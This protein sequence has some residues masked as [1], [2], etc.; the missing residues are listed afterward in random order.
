MPTKPY[1]LQQYVL[2]SVSTLK[3][4]VY[5]TAYANTLI[6]PQFSILARQ[7][8]LTDT[9]LVVLFSWPLR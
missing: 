8:R 7:K 2:F 6:I 1:G 4:C 9:T 3:T 5:Q